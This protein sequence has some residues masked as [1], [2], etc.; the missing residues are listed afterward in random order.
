MGREY[1][2]LKARPG[3]TGWSLFRLDD[4]LVGEEPCAV[5]GGG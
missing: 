3:E 5:K 2:S 1:H 4:A